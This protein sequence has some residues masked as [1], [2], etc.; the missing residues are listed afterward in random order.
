M[1]A[2]KDGDPDNDHKDQIGDEPTPR[3]ERHCVQK[4]RLAGSE[5]SA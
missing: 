2:G 3:G 4:A 5:Q 1:K